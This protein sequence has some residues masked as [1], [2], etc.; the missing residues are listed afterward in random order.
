MV[1]QAILATS[2]VNGGVRRFVAFGKHV[3]DFVNG[4]AFYWV[5]GII[6]I[7]DLVVFGEF[8]WGNRGLVGVGIHYLEPFV[9]FF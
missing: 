7:R 5:F 9:V 4:L 2:E 8:L 6:G 1:S 3:G